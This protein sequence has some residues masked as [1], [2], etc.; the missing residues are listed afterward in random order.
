MQK[1]PPQSVDDHALYV[2]LLKYAVTRDDLRAEQLF[3]ALVLPIGKLNEAIVFSYSPSKSQDDKQYYVLYGYMNGRGNTHNFIVLKA[4]DSLEDAEGLISPEAV[5]KFVMSRGRNKF[6]T[7]WTS[8]PYLVTFHIDGE[9]RD[10]GSVDKVLVEF[11]PAMA[12][13]YVKREAGQ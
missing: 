7:E 8:G 1:R 10:N 12:A 9:E 4:D 13:K 2:Q 3:T 5:R 11:Y 6:V